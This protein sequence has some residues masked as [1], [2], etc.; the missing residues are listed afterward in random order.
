MKSFA[1]SS[2]AAFDYQTSPRAGAF[3]GVADVCTFVSLLV[4]T[5]P[6][7][8]MEAVTPSQSESALGLEE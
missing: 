4:L 5:R 3:L 6:L 2:C 8:P 1:H 7:D